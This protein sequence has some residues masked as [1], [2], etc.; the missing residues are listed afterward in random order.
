MILEAPDKAETLMRL[1]MALFAGIIIGFERE[2]HG[3][4]AG[5]RTTM[6]VSVSSALAMILSEWLFVESGSSL[7]WRPDPARLAA[8][9]LT[10][11]G[12]LGAGAIVRQDKLIR[13]VTTAAV[14]WFVTI[15]GL[16]YGSGNFLLGNMGL[17]IAL[18]ALFILPQVEGRIKNDWYGT[19]I[20]TAQM[21]SISDL[22][23]RKQ[24]ESFKVK[25]KKMDL[26]YNLEK[27]QKTLRCELKFKK[28]DLFELSQKVVK[29][30]SESSGV[31]Q[32]Q[33]M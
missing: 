23:I 16:A 15:L 20:V 21:N 25:V 28:G 8:G 13:G 29:K 1:G 32:V 17:A 31:S 26:D 4:A 30:L 6:L 18:L 11:M 5:L 24:I 10:G 12:F 2:R 19:L 9:V 3:R 7:T 33:W 27:K 14:L 22:E